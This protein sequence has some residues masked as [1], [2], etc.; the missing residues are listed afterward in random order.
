M[1]SLVQNLRNSHGCAAPD[2]A[3]PIL[4]PMRALAIVGAAAALLAGTAATAHATT[5]PRL[6]IADDLPLTLRGAGFRSGEAVRVTVRMGS[7]RLTRRARAGATGRFTVRFRRVR[8]NYCATPLT[9]VARGS[10]SGSVRA[11]IPLRECA[12][13]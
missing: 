6:R 1:K 5:K 9:I 2:S 4:E 13:P 11:P 10:R 12:A 3:A 8:L 7:S